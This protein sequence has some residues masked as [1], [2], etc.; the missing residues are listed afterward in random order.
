MATT[1]VLG[2]CF[3]NLDLQELSE[4][5]YL[6]MSQMSTLACAVSSAILSMIIFITFK[7]N[8]GK[9]GGLALLITVIFALGVL[10][11]RNTLN[12]RFKNKKC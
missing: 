3:K 7:Q 1:T 11:Y 5:A 6:G 9:F 4:S 12:N 2:Q 10:Y 8:K